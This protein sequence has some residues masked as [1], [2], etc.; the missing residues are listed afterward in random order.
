MKLELSD[1]YILL[2]DNY[3]ITLAKQRKVGKGKECL[4]Y[5]GYYSSFKHAIQGCIFH[6][7]KTADVTGL[8]DILRHIDNFTEQVT[9]AIEKNCKQEMKNE[10]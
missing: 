7:L 8:H 1:G 9:E 2:T 6:N 4:D 10:K 3:N 5:I